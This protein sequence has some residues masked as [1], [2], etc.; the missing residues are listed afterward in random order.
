VTPASLIGER[1][2]AL[3]QRERFLLLL[4]AAGVLLFAVI[5]F[6]LYPAFDSYRKTRASIPQ[7]QGTLARYRLAAQGEERVDE[8]LADA[9]ERLEAMEEGILPGENP[10]A[11]GAALQGILKPWVERADTR[12]TSIR[13]LAPVQKGPYAEVAVQMDLQTTTQGLAALLSQVPHHP[14]ILRVKKLSVSSGYYGPAGQNRRE[15]VQV[16]VVVA[17]LANAVVDTR[18]E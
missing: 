17:G 10:A 14:K 4:G 9:A 18:G 1:F 15:V 7:R 16:S 6:G 12:L 8:A 13:G 2:R 11:A 3:S 5:R